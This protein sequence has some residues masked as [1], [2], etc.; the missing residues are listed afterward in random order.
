MNIF[1]L[2]GQAQFSSEIR[3]T[4]SQGDGDEKEE[5]GE[6]NRREIRKRG[7]RQ[8]RQKTR[9]K[10][11]NKRK[12]EIGEIQRREKR[13]TAREFVSARALCDVSTPAGEC[14]HHRDALTRSGSVPAGN[15][16]HVTAPLYTTR[17]PT[18]TPNSAK[19]WP[20]RSKPQFIVCCARPR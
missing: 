7:T 13:K 4:E 3:E 20:A 19:C 16:D 5:E 14:T 8:R 18:T 12:K 15:W 2:G 17:H 1:F 11:M 10:E 6:T 9:Q